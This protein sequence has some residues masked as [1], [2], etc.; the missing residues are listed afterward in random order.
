MIR[1]IP[2]Q[3]FMSSR[4]EASNFN[5]VLVRF[6]PTE[7]E[8]GFFQIARGDLR[9]F[10]SEQSPWFGRHA[11]TGKRQFRSLILD[12]LDHFWML[13]S[14]IGVDQL[15]CEIE[16]ALSIRIPE[17]N[18]LRLY[19][20]NRIHLPLIGPGIKRIFLVEIDNFFGCELG[21]VVSIEKLQADKYAGNRYTVSLI[22]VFPGYLFTVSFL[23][24]SQH[25]HLGSHPYPHRCVRNTGT[26]VRARHDRASHRGQLLSLPARD[27]WYGH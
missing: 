16:I 12:R 26:T 23:S 6:R 11:G 22:Y 25:I 21:H 13:V 18:S 2:R 8:K 17:V 3:D 10:L 9:Q 19:H 15:G 4:V 27:T 20:R 14:D 7:R 24:Q 1:A 5:R